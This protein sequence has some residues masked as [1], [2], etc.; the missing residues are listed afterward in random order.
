M[1]TIIKPSV[2]S[3]TAKTVQSTSPFGNPSSMPIGAKCI[4]SAQIADPGSR[5]L[6]SCFTNPYQPQGKYLDYQD[7]A[8]CLNKLVLKATYYDRA[9]T[10]VQAWLPDTPASTA[11]CVS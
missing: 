11:T 2:S 3:S 6:N 5:V 4:R 10:S 9:L 1:C 8:Y 7:E